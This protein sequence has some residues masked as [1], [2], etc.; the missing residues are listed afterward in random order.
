MP[1]NGICNRTALG[2]V[3]S[4]PMHHSL[5]LCLQGEMVEDFADISRERLERTFKI[6]SIQVSPLCWAC[7]I[8]AAPLAAKPALASCCHSAS[9]AIAHISYNADNGP[10][11]QAYQPMYGIM[12]YASTKVRW[13]KS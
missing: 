5:L 9:C 4:F 6:A 12:D 3:V 11:V 13:C 1:T 10:P 8:L 2:S 7:S